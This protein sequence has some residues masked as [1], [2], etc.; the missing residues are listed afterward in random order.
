MQHKNKIQNP[1][2]NPKWTAL[3]WMQILDKS[4]HAFREARASV[5]DKAL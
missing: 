1:K 5:T 3:V 4:R 2:L